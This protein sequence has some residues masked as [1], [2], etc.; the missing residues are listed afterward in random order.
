MAHLKPKKIHGHTYWYVV[1]SRR[2]DG[3]VKTETLA[4]LGRAD[5]ILARWRGIEKP[6]ERLKSYSHGGVAVLLSLAD[7]LGIGDLIDQHCQASRPSCPTRRLLSVGQTLLLA[8]IGRALHPTSKRGWAAWARTTTLGQLWH[9]D[10]AKIT[11]EFFWDQMDRL[12]VEALPAIQAELARRV[13]KVFGLKT[14]SLFYDV[15]NFYTFIASTNRH[16]DLPQRGRN[17]Q[18][19]SD[20]RQFQ[21]GLLVSQDGWIPLLSIL[22]RGNHNDVTTF[23]QALPEIVRQCEQLDIAVERVTLVCDKGNISKANW[24]V[25]DDSSLG[26]VT[27]IVPSQY[28]EW[29]QRDLR[30]FQTVQVPDVGE[31]RCL[32]A[33]AEIAGKQRTLIVLDSPTLRAGQL[34]GLSQQLHPV[35]MRMTQVQQSL[36]RAKRRRRKE[37]IEKQ[38][39]RFLKPA[40]V[41]RIV[42]YELRPR[43]GKKEYWDLDWWIDQEAYERLRDQVFGRRILVTNRDGWPTESVVCAYWGQSQAEHV[44]RNLKDPHHL[45]LRPQFHWTDQKIQVHA[46]CCLVG[47][48]LAA[49]VRRTARQ[50]DYTQEIGRLLEMLNETRIVL[51]AERRKASGRP[52]IRWQLEE[53]DPD[54]ARLYQTLVSPDYTLGTTPSEV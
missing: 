1:Q 54:A 48:L 42:R 20:L 17:K 3:K 28:P 18:K 45:A 35:M 6:D 8:A 5:D 2:I 15:T 4:Y 23:P 52:R 22:F 32:R 53:N 9:F 24:R 13:R 36:A 33:Q 16:C 14:E 50:M 44:F 49:L 38:I 26:Y 10:V 21:M 39:G 37:L 11:S 43:A 19:R 7:R 31:V 30:D 29:S 40:I 51:R 27:S 46:F 25:L 34:R 47:Y 41:R 12:P